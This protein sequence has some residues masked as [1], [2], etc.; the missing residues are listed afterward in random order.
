[1]KKMRRRV[2]KD[3]IFPS[4]S[5]NSLQPEETQAQGK[6]KL[7]SRGEKV[8]IL[9]LKQVWGRYIILTGHQQHFVLCFVASLSGG[10]SEL[11]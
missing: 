6:R 7:G 10:L 8:G 2:I 5:F 11:G 1:M 3:V 4:T 9:I